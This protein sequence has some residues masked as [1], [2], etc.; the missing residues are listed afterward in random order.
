MKQ[1]VQI[2]FSLL[3]TFTGS[4]LQAQ[5]RGID[6]TWKSQKA[7]I[8]NGVEAEAVI[9]LGDIDNLG[10][11][12]PANFNPFCDLQ[13]ES[14]SKLKPV[15]PADIPGFDKLIFSPNYKPNAKRS[16]SSDDW[17]DFFQTSH[18][19]PVPFT[20]QCDSV[21]GML[22][23]DAELQIFITDI[24]ALTTC[25]RY[26]LQINQERY[27]EG[28]RILNSLE[29]PSGVGRLISI[30]LNPDHCTSIAEGRPLVIHI[31]EKSGAAD[32]YAIDFIQVL[33]NQSTRFACYGNIQGRLVN[34]SGQEPI[35]GAQIQIGS[36]ITY[37]DTRG[38]YA[39]KN[40]EAGFQE[41][42]I[43]CKGCSDFTQLLNVYASKD[44]EDQ[45]FYIDLNK[46][47][48][49]Y[50][51]QKIKIGELVKLRGL[52]ISKERN[53][54]L[55]GS[56]TSL[57]KLAAYLMQHPTWEIEIIAES[58]VSPDLLIKKQREFSLAKYCK[59]YILRFGI[60]TG[61]VTVKHDYEKSSQVKKLY[62]SDQGQ[63]WISFRITKM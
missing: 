32:A 13:F 9:R 1:A 50:Y 52:Q 34:K 42:K 36:S 27:V 49:V 10:M 3:I 20:I 47:D 5:P 29:L 30:P 15:K 41:M 44:N 7:F 57:D 19:T 2:L 14:I 56:T 4:L 23:A 39:L 48:L 38:V 62:Q 21:K 55:D 45:V 11:G 58:M 18:S 24:Q 8:K 46:Q 43:T 40:I 37:T 51:D 35:V 33:I 26:T 17:S 31:E 25:S 16:C 63:E 12:W 6:T 60:D 28:E 54:I 61:R 22:V 53:T 59:K